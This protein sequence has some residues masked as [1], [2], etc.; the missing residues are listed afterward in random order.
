MY[1][2]I[3]NN[4]F[5]SNFLISTIFIIFNIIF[6]FIVS[7][8]LTRSKIILFSNFQPLIIFFTIFFIYTFLLNILILLNYHNFFKHILL[9]TFFFQLI[10]FFKNY[11]IL[12]FKSYKDIKLT[13][14]QKYIIFILVSF[15][16][17]SI[18]PIS[19]SDSIALHQNIANQLYLFGIENI[20]FQYHI[21]FSILSNS[22]ILLVLSPI[23]N[24]DNFGSQLNILTFI[25]F[26]FFTYKTQKNFALIL[27]SCPLIIYFISAQKLQLFFGILYLLIFIIIN[28]KLIK[29]K[30]GFFFIILLLAFYASANLNYILLSIPL[31]LF[32]IIKFKELWRDILNFSI[33]SFIIVVFPLF[34][35]KHVYFGNILAPFFEDLIGSNNINYDAYAFALRSTEGW[36][37][38]PLNYEYYIRPFV[39]F[40]VEN[41]SSSLGL[42][43]LFM[44]IDFKMLKNLKYFPVLLILLVLSTGQIL[45]RYYFE[46]FLI[47]AYYYKNKDFLPKLVIAGSNL[48]ILTMTILFIFISYVKLNVIINKNDFLNNFAYSY[49]NSNQ[50]KQ[51]TFEENILDLTID[52]DSTFYKKI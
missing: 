24:S 46:S 6:S 15:Y 52:R 41:L 16:L 37:L 32:L 33:L 1:E 45:P 31:F 14:I 10:Y 36:L 18:L 34:I 49:F 38:D 17:I 26:L 22:H 50:N 25:F 48:I 11:R 44:L 3:F 20:D 27:F 13:K 29:K 39:S 40:R 30:I 7:N 42:I 23:L 47:L 5:L 51:L 19:D 12:N 21:N 43:F 4:N 9:I 2:T 8:K 28:E 35:I